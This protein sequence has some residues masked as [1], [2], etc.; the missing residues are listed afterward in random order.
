MNPTLSGFLALQE[1]LVSLVK[2]IDL[3]CYVDDMPEQYRAVLKA[4]IHQAEQYINDLVL[5][6]KGWGIGDVV[7]GQFSEIHYAALGYFV[8]EGH[9]HVNVRLAVLKK[10]GTPSKKT[11]RHS[12]DAALIK[13]G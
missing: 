5:S 11:T 6:R 10:D 3:K 13:V 9:R 7:K 1:D 4:Q 8:P 12:L 2:L